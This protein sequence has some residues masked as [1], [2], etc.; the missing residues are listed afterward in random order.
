[1]L[2][3]RRREAQKTKKTPVAQKAEKQL[4]VD[5]KKLI[6]ERINKKRPNS[7]QGYR[8]IPSKR[9]RSDRREMSNR[10]NRGNHK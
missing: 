9:D 4:R 1:M 3:G 7:R 8:R 6:R 2:F 5:M 10:D